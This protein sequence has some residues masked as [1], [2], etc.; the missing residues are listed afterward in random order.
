[1]PMHRTTLPGGRE[2]PPSRGFSR[3]QGE[4]G[5]ALIIMTTVVATILLIFLLGNIALHAKSQNNELPAKRRV[6]L[7]RAE[8]AVRLWYR[9][10]ALTIDNA[11]CRT[12]TEKELFEETMVTHEYGVRMSITPCASNESTLMS[13]KRGNEIQYR[14]IAIWIP[15]DGSFADPDT[16]GFTDDFTG[17]R[18]HNS[19]VQ[20]RLIE[21][22]AIEAKMMAETKAQ[23][24]E[25]ARLL[26][27]WARAKTDADPERDISL[28]YFAAYDCDNEKEGEIPCFEDTNTVTETGTGK[29][30]MVG[31]ELKA[32]HEDGRALKLA[33]H[34]L[35]PQ[36]MNKDAWGR[37]ILIANK[38]SKP[39]STD[40]HPCLT[41][42]EPN[43]DY[44]PYRMM[45]QSITPW[46][47]VVTVCPVQSIN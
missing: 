46:G 35:L 26:E 16:S 17:F 13:E 12:Y 19:L 33:G 41:E 5:S 4:R 14:N 21:G 44:P 28:N 40:V 3:Y 20:Y 32:P 30:I 10:N 37:N 45:L 2:N 39:A 36:S 31:E 1:M 7:D 8:E 25:M 11:V 43:P 27:L 22:Y 38:L 24:S 9:K 18:P 34:A 42:D 29:N 6:F 47:K 15:A 23:L